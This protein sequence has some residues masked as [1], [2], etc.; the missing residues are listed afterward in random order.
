[1]LRRCRIYTMHASVQIS[2]TTLLPSTLQ[3]TTTPIACLPPPQGLNGIA[4]LVAALP[5]GFLA[6]RYLLCSTRP[7]PLP[8]SQ[9]THITEHRGWARI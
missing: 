3:A 9:Q 5:A 4:Q 7:L 1:M 8:C 2:C 6:D